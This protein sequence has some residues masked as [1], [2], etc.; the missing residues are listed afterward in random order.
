[1]S[2]SVTQRVRDALLKSREILF[3]ELKCVR[4]SM[5]IGA[6][7]GDGWHDEG[8]KLGIANELRIASQLYANARQLGLCSVIIPEEQND[9][10]KIGNVV[11]VKYLW[12]NKKIIFVVD[13]IPSYND[14]CSVNSPLGRSLIGKKKGD[15]I[16]IDGGNVRVRIEKIF[17]PSYYSTFEQTRKDP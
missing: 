5:D 16:T 4:E 3:Q 1:M 11:E 14:V 8:Y 17:P 13:G 7:T 2:I 12:D 6:A 15:V 10:V 9:I